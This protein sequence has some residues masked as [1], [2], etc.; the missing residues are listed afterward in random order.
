MSQRQHG[1]KPG[2][3]RLFFDPAPA[4]FGAA[5]DHA[6]RRFHHMIDRAVVERSLLRWGF[7]LI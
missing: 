3:A 4:L 5:L 6:L 2:N 7:P 1:K